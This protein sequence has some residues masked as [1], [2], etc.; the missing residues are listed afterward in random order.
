MF[1]DTRLITR[2]VALLAVLLLPVAAHAA[3]PWNKVQSENFVVVGDVGYGRLVAVARTLEQFR[4]ATSLIFPGRAVSAQRPLTVIVAKSETMLLITENEFVAGLY[5]RGGDH[6]YI[7][8]NDDMPHETAMRVALHEYQHLINHATW[9]SL[10]KWVDEGLSEFYSTFDELDGGK[11]YYVGVPIRNHV[12]ALNNWGRTR[13]IDFMAEDGRTS[14]SFNEI[15][16]IGDFYAQSWALVHF[17]A[18]GDNGRWSEKFAPLIAALARGEA[19]GDAFRRI[20]TANV[21]E[22]E[23]AFKLYLERETFSYASLRNESG[24]DIPTERGR[25]SMVETDTLKGTLFANL[26]LA[27]LAVRAARIADPA[28]RPAAAQAARLKLWM[29]DED[30]DAALTAY[31]KESP[32]DHYTC[33]MAMFTLN[34][35]RRFDE[36]LAACPAASTHLGVAFERMVALEG[37]GRAAEAGP[38]RAH[39]LTAPQ[40][41]VAELYWRTWRYLEDGGYVA[42]RRAAVAAAA[43]DNNGTNSV[44]YLRIAGA[45]AQALGGDIEAARAELRRA[46][47]PAGA[48]EWVQNVA[49]YLLGEIDAP[50]LIARA[51]GKYE[52]TEAHAYVGLMLL[53]AGDKAGAAEH[54]VWVTTRG[55]DDVSEYYVAKA[56]YGRLNRP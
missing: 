36:A 40:R 52:Q 26:D 55:S 47:V 4:L 24:G 56:H 2:V 8:M 15:F 1:I 45:M 6:D 38:Q 30:A 3:E 32:D 54:L 27:S 33:G 46:P 41:D 25:L 34:V 39:L 49:R 48:A 50:T 5:R 51:K 7:V 14:A 12:R 53:A 10:P 9:T 19:A 17:F 29:R 42:A 16:K 44:A 28:H 43:R 23:T 21:E 22:F 35:A 20:V 37:L 18:L 13:V 11:T 31:A